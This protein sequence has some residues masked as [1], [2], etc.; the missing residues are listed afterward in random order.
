ME[1][2][3]LNFWRLYASMRLVVAGKYG[4]RS[5]TR[6]SPI[7]RTKSMKLTHRATVSILALAV[8]ASMGSIGLTALQL[9]PQRGV[10]DVVTSTAI[11]GELNG[12]SDAV[13]DMPMA[14]RS[15]VLARHGVSSEQALADS[16]DAQRAHLA[17]AERERANELARSDKRFTLL[18]VLAIFN[19]SAAALGTI[20][21]Y[22]AYRTKRNHSTQ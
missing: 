18:L 16:L 19:V 12:V 22:E 14:A 5:R 8:V 4:I 17:Q 10:V 6:A 3:T 15:D 7:I 9:R 2:K 20:S 13:K 21:L 11:V 1:A